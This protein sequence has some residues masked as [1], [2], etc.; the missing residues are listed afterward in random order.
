VEPLSEKRVVV[1]CLFQLKLADSTVRI[2]EFAGVDVLADLEEIDAWSCSSEPFG[3]C[4]RE[5]D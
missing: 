2:C 4:C 1:D 5:I 3:K